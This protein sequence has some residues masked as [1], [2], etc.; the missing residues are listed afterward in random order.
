MIKTIDR[1]VTKELLVTCGFAVFA[2]SVVLILGNILRRLLDL[3]LNHDVPLDYVLNFIGYL[4]PFSLT[5]TI[6]WGFLTAT[7]L[8]F[9]KMSAENEMTALRSSGVSIVRVCTPIFL[10]SVI[11]CGI[12]LWLGADVAP[13]AQGKMRDSLLHLV[14]T[15]PLVLFGSDQVITQFPNRKIYVG[16]KV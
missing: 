8:V 9:G 6:P 2:L 12:C 16:E 5:F 4:I 10:M 1:Y 13:R 7:L 15:N 3:L 11:F 14:T